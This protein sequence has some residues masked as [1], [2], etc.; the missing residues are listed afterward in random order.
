MTKARSTE[1]RGKTPHQDFANSLHCLKL[2][3][4]LYLCHGC[5]PEPQLFLQYPQ[6]HIEHPSKFHQQSSEWLQREWVKVLL[7]LCSLED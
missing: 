6:Q 1:K 5:H 2:G 4:K 3:Q 7:K